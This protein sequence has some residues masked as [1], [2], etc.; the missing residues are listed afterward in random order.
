M[1]MQGK[2][3]RIFPDRWGFLLQ[4]DLAAGELDDLIKREGV[5]DLDDYLV[6][7][8]LCIE[9]RLG[10]IDK[11]FFLQRFPGLDQGSKFL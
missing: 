9:D 6:S 2:A 5:K 7:A 3:P 10:A 4:E 1:K 8:E 11:L